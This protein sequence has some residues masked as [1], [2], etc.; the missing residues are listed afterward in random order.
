[1]YLGASWLVCQGVTENI[2]LSTMACWEVQALAVDLQQQDVVIACEDQSV[3][4]YM[5]QGTDGKHG[6]IIKEIKSRIEIFNSSSFVF[7]K[8]ATCK[9]PDA[10]LSRGSRFRVQL[11]I[12]AHK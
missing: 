9:A 12:E 6:M 4:Q 11:E 3:V 8:R 7:T 10:V 2:C 5:N 1:M